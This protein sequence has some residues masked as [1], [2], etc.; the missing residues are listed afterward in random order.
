[1]SPVLRVT[2]VAY[3]RCCVSIYWKISSSSIKVERRELDAPVELDY[4]GHQQLLRLSFFTHLKALGLASSR[5][6][7]G[8]GVVRR[9]IDCKLKKKKGLVVTAFTAVSPVAISAALRRCSDVD[10]APRF[11]RPL[12]TEA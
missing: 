6:P 8:E 11:L 12:R 9:M 5:R 4:E 3:H 7:R 10:P 1:M 2:G